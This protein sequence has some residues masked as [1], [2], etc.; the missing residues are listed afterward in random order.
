[1]IEN[2]FTYDF[3]KQMIQ[4]AKSKG[5]S[6]SFYGEKPIDKT[7]ILRHDIDSDIKKALALAKI[8]HQLG[9]KST[10]FVLLRTD[11]YNPFSK[12]SLEMLLKIISL[13]HEVGL[14]F[15]EKSYEE[16]CDIVDEVKNEVKLL[17][18]LINKPVR[19][20]SMHRPS[21]KTLDANY[22]F[23]YI[24]NSYSQEYF[25]NYKYISDSRRNWRE[26]PFEVIESGL[27]NKLHI[28]THAFWY[29]KD[30]SN[31]KNDIKNF[32]IDGKKDR[33]LS[34]MSNITNLSDIVEYSEV[35]NE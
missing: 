18:M 28:L 22:R 8:E 19:V 31:I 16:D 3:Y 1:M 35:I 7:I 15:D 25:N 2:E 30:T 34:L 13:G 26:N 9:V 29:H 10:Y 20:V 27:Y 32:I 11:F 5:Y 24:I 6:F 17:S 21:R 33:Y 14:H 4:L 12:E 23:D